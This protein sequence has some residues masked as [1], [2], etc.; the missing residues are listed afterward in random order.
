MPARLAGLTPELTS[1]ATRR[2]HATERPPPTTRG[3]CGRRLVFMT[4]SIVKCS[5]VIV[6][7]PPGELAAKRAPE[8]NLDTG[9]NTTVHPWCE[10]YMLELTVAS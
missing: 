1:L 6:R 8:A 2:S 4:Q 3:M 5:P 7:L 9:A 10:Q